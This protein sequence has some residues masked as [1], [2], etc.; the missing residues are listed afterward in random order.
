MEHITYNIK[1]KKEKHAYYS[2]FPACANLAGRHVPCYVKKG[3]AGYSILE[4]LVVVAI[5]S[6]LFVVVF[7][8]FPSI[9]LQL[10]LS[11]AAYAFEQD[12]RRAQG[13]SLSLAEYNLQP[14]KGFGAHVDLLNNKQYIVYADSVPDDQSYTGVDYIVNTVELENGIIIKEINNII[15]N[16]VSINFKP[17]NPIITITPTP[18]QNNV[19]VV[20]AIASDL[21][22]IKT[23]SINTAGLVEVLQ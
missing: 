22:K 14:V 19:K 12:L 21:T 15:G 20:F 9:K 11:R 17:P 7:S 2:M 8:N 3:G 10:A 23:V 5:I 18:S 4:L 13:M 16:T 1:Y 6:V